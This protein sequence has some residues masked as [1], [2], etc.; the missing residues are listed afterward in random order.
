MASPASFGYVVLF[1]ERIVAVIRD[2]VKIEVE[3]NAAFES[4]IS[5]GIKPSLHE[6]WVTLWW[7]AAGVFSQE[8]TFRDLVEPGKAAQS[9]VED[10]AHDVAM[11]HIPK[12]LEGE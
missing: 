9:L 1:N 3:R 4:E 5:H 11:A 10:M 8:R 12:K 2:R 6:F 7:D